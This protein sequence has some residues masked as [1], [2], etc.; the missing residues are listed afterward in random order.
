[1][2]CLLQ[3]NYVVVLVLLYTLFGIDYP[4]LCR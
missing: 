1:M 4:W 2:V 3:L